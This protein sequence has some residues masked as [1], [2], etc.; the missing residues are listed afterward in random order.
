MTGWGP[1]EYL[2]FTLVAI[3]AAIMA[4]D[5]AMKASPTMG[6]ATASFR[7]RGWWGYA[8]AVLLIAAIVVFLLRITGTIGSQSIHQ[9][10]VVVGIGAEV[11]GPISVTD[12]QG[13]LVFEVKKGQDWKGP[14]K[15]R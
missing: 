9:A 4:I 15:K 6:P 3:P 11:K 5:T 10:G 14:T 13:N 1:F 2:V 12:D 8:P 7:E